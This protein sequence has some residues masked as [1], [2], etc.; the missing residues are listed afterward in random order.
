MLVERVARHGG[1]PERSVPLAF[2]AS[3]SKT[4]AGRF[5]RIFVLMP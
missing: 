3:F 2:V 1:A 5:T 4:L